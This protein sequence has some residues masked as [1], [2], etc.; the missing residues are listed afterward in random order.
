MSVLSLTFDTGALIALERGDKRMR[1]VLETATLDDVRITVPAV[2][3]AEWWRGHGR[4]R[5][6]ILASVDVEPTSE[7]VARVAG[8]VM[9]ALPSATA[10]DAIVMASAAQRGGIVYTSDLEDLE[11]LRKHF[12]GIRLLRA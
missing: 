12:P 3:V 11:R 2:V 8:E 1:V 4:R 10:I 7:H 5:E 6:A 9:A